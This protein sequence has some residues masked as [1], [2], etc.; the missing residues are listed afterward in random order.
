MV[1]ATLVPF[2]NQQLITLAFVQL[3]NAFVFVFFARKSNLLLGPRPKAPY[4]C[5]GTRTNQNDATSA[6][7]IHPSSELL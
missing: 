6:Y 7:L 2:I 1:S 3:S 5:N 4:T